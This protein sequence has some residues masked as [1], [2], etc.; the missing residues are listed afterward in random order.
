MTH[1]DA[2]LAE[3]WRHSPTAQ[4]VALGL[5]L[6]PVGMLL[7]YLFSARGKREV[8]M[9]GALKGSLAAATAMLV[10]GGLLIVAA[11]VL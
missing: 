7:A 1:D 10:V 4:G 2:S 5:V 6:G 9:F 8:R 3:Q 11:S